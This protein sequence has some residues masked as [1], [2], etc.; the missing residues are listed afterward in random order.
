MEAPVARF[1]E[2]YC[3]KNMARFHMPG[4]KGHVFFGCEPLDI[5]EIPG[6]DVLYHGDGII[7]E[8]E[9]NAG[10]LFGSG[11][12]HYSAGGSTHCIK[13]MLA[14]LVMESQAGG[15]AQ[16]RYLLAGRNVHRSMV[17]AC[18]LLDLDLEFVKSLRDGHLC[19]DVISPEELRA[20]LDSRKGRLPL[21]V[22]I[23]SPDYLGQLADV[24]GLAEACRDFGV[25]LV[26]DNA[27]GAYLHFLEEPCHP[28]DVGAAMCC[29]SA[30][31]TLPALTG[32]AYLHIHRE[33]LEQ[34][35]PYAKQA[36]QVFGSTS[37]SY[38]ILQSLDLCNVYLA[39]K[40]RKKLSLV[41]ALA[42]QAENELVEH[43][44]CIR[45]SEPL[46]IVIHAGAHGIS[47]EETAQEMRRYQ[48]E[49][50]YADD[51]F[52]VLMLSPE[53][54]ERDFCRLLR[55]GKESRLRG[56]EPV[57]GYAGGQKAVLPERCMTIREAVFCENELIAPQ[58]A[59]GRICAA[60]TVS[61]PPAVPIAISGERI[62]QEMA[63]T[64]LHYGISKVSVVKRR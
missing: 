58:E 55:W 7:S 46:K 49:C 37:P 30:H 28:M 63:E 47:G 6:A 16:R 32:A 13:S 48:I 1:V 41:T 44:I 25:P 22:Y 62:S 50:E 3:N 26:V 15:G 11:K 9:K 8:S 33:Y 60:E 12:T 2:A 38:L 34:F 40:I 64:F 35:E 36:L 10:I 45:P 14:V 23:T 43:G 5:T 42:A 51:S 56:S 61:C 18:A 27:H 21:A 59:V 57:H 19:S 17:D 20:A 39:D 54:E 52:V 53:T 29:D 4:H 24:R 31:K